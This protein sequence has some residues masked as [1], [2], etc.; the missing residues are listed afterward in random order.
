MQRLIIAGFLEPTSGEVLLDGKPILRPGADRAVIFQEPVALL[1]WLNVADNVAFGLK[2]KGTLKEERDTVAEH[3]LELVGLWEFR[4]RAIY[5]L[6]V[7]MQQRVTLCRVL[8][9]EPSLSVPWTPLPG[10]RCKE[11][12]LSSGARPGRP[13]SSLPTAWRIPQAWPHH[14]QVHRQVWGRLRRQHGLE[15]PRFRRR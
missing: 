1:P 5:E 4:K 14:R 12:C 3:Y 6:S 9:N 8:A 13:S 15:L 7:G 2:L 10:I 11:S